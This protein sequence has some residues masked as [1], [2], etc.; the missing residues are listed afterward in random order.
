MKRVT[1]R[2]KA[3][4]GIICKVRFVEPSKDLAIALISAQTF[5]D[6]FLRPVYVVKPLRSPYL[7]VR[8]ALESTDLVYAG[9]LPVDDE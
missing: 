4:T 6:I 5:A 7:V 3:W 2:L 8:V 1:R 9:C